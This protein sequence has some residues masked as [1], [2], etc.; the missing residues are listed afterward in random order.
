MCPKI[1]AFGRK[2]GRLQDPQN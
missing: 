1:I 2:T